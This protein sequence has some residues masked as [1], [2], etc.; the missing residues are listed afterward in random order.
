VFAPTVLTILGAIM[1]LRE[2]WVV[3]N[4]G[5][6]GAVLIILLAHVITVTTALSVSSVATNIRVG[7]GGA[8][9]II[10]QSLGLEAGGSIGIPLYLARTTSAVLYV[11]AFAEGWLWLY[12]H[13]SASLVALLTLFG[14]FG[15]AFASTKFAQS[16]QV[17]IL[18]VVVASLIS[19]GLGAVPLAESWTWEFIHIPAQA[20][21]VHEPQLW[22][23]FSQADFWE[24]F[25]IF[26]P[27]VTGIVAGISL[28]DVLENPR[29]AIP[30]GTLWGVGLTMVLYLGLAY[31]LACLAPPEELLQNYTVMLDRAMFRWM[32]LAGLLG[33]TLSSALGSLVAAPRV[34]QA[35]GA[36]K[37][38]P[39][40]AALAR[41]SAS[42]E[43]RLA[44]VVTLLITLA[45]LLIAILGGGLNFVAPLITM[46]FLLTYAM[47]NLVV[48]IE[49]RLDMVTFRPTF[50]IPK[51]VPFIGVTSSALVMFLIAP[52]FSLFAVGVS[53]GLYWYLMQRR[54]GRTK[55]GDVRSGLF[56]SMA[57]WAAE[58]VTR[59]P[60][61]PERTWQ[62][63]LLVPVSSTAELVGGFRL[64]RAL[65]CHGQGG[66]HVIG[67]HPPGQK[68]Q[69][70]RL[71]TVARDF[72][73]DHVFSRAST[74]EQVEFRRGIDAGIHLLGATIFRPNVLFVRLLPDRDL[75]DMTTLLSEA[76]EHGMGVVLLST[77]PVQEFGQEQRI[78]VWV[79]S[80]APEWKLSLRLSNLDLSLL[81]AYQLAR[82]W[83]GRIHLCMAVQDDSIREDAES[84]LNDL[85]HLSRLTRWMTMHVLVGSFDEALQQVPQG[86]LNILG[87]P[88]EPTME[89]LR[90]LTQ[91]V[92]TCLL[93]RDSGNES[94]LA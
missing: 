19:F 88:P 53:A 91:K 45:T 34:L 3:G 87:L 79:R 46:F 27:A 16:I 59:V 18:L 12:P 4:A 33:A 15:I 2:G 89:G 6:L 90:K 75:G 1:Y 13:H 86:D 21:L 66:V 69:V 83:G 78:N 54:L 44:G 85:M 37:V 77:D 73:R 41:M 61:A 70:A 51:L 5:L 92:G 10:A 65:T 56:L 29:S 11:L 81:L 49:Q 58:A 74:L 26:F 57:K 40:S 20:G 28:S 47:L 43:P 31:W 80:Q 55:E 76:K 50:R 7:A 84:F 23:E 72:G 82:E 68:D 60:A 8:Y 38:I 94:V 24:T 32:V 36:H 39:G 25:A 17:V 14:V 64:L 42:G 30:T 52:I 63:H 67:I 9:A 71:P 22:G 62:P 35:L 48:L 93:V